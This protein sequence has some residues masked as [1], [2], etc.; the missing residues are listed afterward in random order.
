MAA[1]ARGAASAGAWCL[2]HGGVGTA[3]QLGEQLGEVK[4]VV[5]VGSSAPADHGARHLMRTRVRPRGSGSCVRS[6]MAAS[7]HPSEIE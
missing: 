3:G 1:G 7:S 5:A 4:L 6:A 2:A